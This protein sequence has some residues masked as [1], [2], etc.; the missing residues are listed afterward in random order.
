MRGIVIPAIFAVFI[1]VI[2]SNNVY[3]DPS[4]SM[5]ASQATPGSVIQITGSG[6][7]SSD[8]SVTVTA[9]NLGE[10]TKTYTSV[11]GTHCQTSVGGLTPPSGTFVCPAE[12][13]NQVN[14][15]ISGGSFSCYFI[16]PE[17]KGGYSCSTAPSCNGN[18]LATIEATGDSGDSAELSGAILSGISV[19]PNEGPATTQA[20]LYGTGWLGLYVIK[21]LPILDI[22]LNLYS[23]DTNAGPFS[24]NY[25]YQAVIGGIG[26]SPTHC[27]PMPDGKLSDNGPCTFSFDVA[28]NPGVNTITAN[29]L[30]T[31]D[32]PDKTF[33]ASYLVTTPMASLSAHASP[34]GSSVTV[35]GSGFANSD[36]SVSL[37]LEGTNIT[38]S[39]GCPLSDGIFSCT[40]IVP[41]VHDEIGK[42]IYAVGTSGDTALAGLFYALPVPSISLSKSSGPLGTTMTITGSNF[43]PADNIAYFD[44]EPNPFIQF[45]SRSEGIGACS[46]SDGSITGTCSITLPLLG[47]FSISPGSYNIGVVGNDGDRGS[48]PFTVMPS[49]LV[50]L[51]TTSALPQTHVTVTGSGFANSDTSVTLTFDG[52]SVTPSSGC[53]V[54]DGSFSCIF[55]V[56]SVSQGNYNPLIVQANSG[57]GNVIIFSVLGPTISL[58]TSSGPPGTLVT[59][60]GTLFS[61]SDTSI[62]LTLGSTNVTP[63]S[64]CPVTGG[65]FSCTIAVPSI[66]GGSK[67]FTVL[68]S[69]GDTSP[70]AQFTVLNDISISSSS[71]PPGTILTVTGSGFSSSDTSATVNFGSTTVT[72]SSGCPVIGGTLSCNITVPSVA[73][74]SYP[75]TVV[76]S[77]GDSSISIQFAVADGISIYP[78]S[79]SIGTLITVSGTGFRGSSVDVVFIENNGGA[80]DETTVATCPVSGASNTLNS[81]TGA[82]TFTIP[83]DIPRTDTVSVSDSHN[84]DT[85]SV[86]ITIPKQNMVLSPSSG[87]I[88]AVV[89]INGTGFSSSDTSVQVTTGSDATG[90]F[91]TTFCP[92]TGGSFTCS[93]IMPSTYVGDILVNGGFVGHTFDVPGGSY[94]F[95]AVGTPSRDV[96]TDTFTVVPAITLNPSS[97]LPGSSMTVTGTGFS[98]SDTSVTLKLGSTDVTPLSGCTVSGGFSCTI[99]VPSIPGGSYTMIATGN[100]GDSASNGFTVNKGATTTTVSSSVNTSIIGHLVTLT[101]TTSPTPPASGTPTGTV[102]FSVNGSNISLPVTL[103][104]GTATLGIQNLPAGHDIITASYSGDSNFNGSDNNASAFSQVVNKD[105]T[106]TTISSSDN[107]SILGQEITITADISSTSSGI[108]TGTVTFYDG[109][110]PIGTDTVHVGTT[111]GETGGIIHL[112]SIQISSLSLGSHQITASYKGD[113]NFM[114]STSSGVTQTILPRAPII[115]NPE[116]NTETGGTPTITGIS[117]LNGATITLYNGVVQIGTATADNAGTWSFTPLTPLIGGKYDIT[118][119]ATLGGQTSGQSSVI[120]F[121]VNTT[122]PTIS[123][124][125]PANNTDVNMSTQTLSGTASDVISVSQITWKIDTG[126]V[127]AVSGITPASTINWSFTTPLIPDGFHIIQVNATNSGGLSTSKV[128]AI[129]IDTTPP[130]ITVP[131]DVTREATGPQTIVNFGIATAND[132]IDGSVTVTNNA[133]TSYAVGVTKIQYTATD[134]AGNTAIA[135]QTITITDSTPPVIVPTITGMIGTNNWYTNDVTVSWSVTDPQSA[136]S[137]ST[138]CTTSTINTDTAGTTLTCTATSAGG[139]SSNSVTIKRDATAPTITAPSSITL[140]S[141]TS[142]SPPLGTPT[143]NDNL[144]PSPSVTNNAPASFASGSTTTI[145]WTATDHAGNHAS[146]TQQVTIQTPTQAITGLTNTINGMSLPTGEQTSLGA[147]LKNIDTSSPSSCGKLNAFVS[148]VDNDLSHGK[149]TMSQANAL[150]SQANA[151]KTAIGC[152]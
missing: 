30:I 129:T 117:L 12:G 141:S 137:I 152:K 25:F 34:S 86:P 139:T 20:T 136:I 69:S 15:P 147:T 131:S 56:P 151:I 127:M 85:Y 78:S 21:V 13:V 61:D 54:T 121:T 36:T 110:T 93:I 10:Y 9:S 6:F 11:S 71:G 26:G 68:G 62:A 92:S 29:A 3:A 94:R 14:C 46:L 124:T 59:V 105:T 97:G 51:S 39:S 122:P 135:Y 115:T 53:P 50:S 17:I 101:A 16:V 58:S 83:P 103:S 140:V 109:I 79:G 99:T 107:P 38:P 102:Q 63:S 4:I 89:I 37:T 149:L 43:I 95:F 23:D 120:I 1:L 119:T 31:A 90:D 73:Q 44:L 91:L 27:L 52:N 111:S 70:P 130:V 47:L 40:F 22:S 145:T 116:N 66:P 112:A 72:P 81:I 128:F 150:L 77:S 132:A 144:D 138:G 82:C 8:S 118:A 98:S 33:S 114:S 24:N 80:L 148:K 42:N 106:T 134:L 142:V 19:V 113:G 108:P 64:G 18:E 75:I 55:T 143:V 104:S 57:D 123:I 45:A 32:V 60:T 88:G 126:A 67:Q 100:S 48:A 96:F 49:P 7:S 28:Q 74:N 125:S 41:V 35:N 76:G 87:P 84:I 65:S 146:A 5:S 133:T 2:L